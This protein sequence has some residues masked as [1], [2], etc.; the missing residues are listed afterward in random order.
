MNETKY[1]KTACKWYS[2]HKHK[3]WRARYDFD[4]NEEDIE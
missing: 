1:E 4:E 3:R 2:S